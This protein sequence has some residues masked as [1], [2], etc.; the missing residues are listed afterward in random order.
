[1]KKLIVEFNRLNPMLK[2]MWLVIFTISI[3]SMIAIIVKSTGKDYD[4]S[5]FIST[6]ITFTAIMQVINAF[7][8]MSVLTKISKKEAN[9]R[10]LRKDIFT[11][12]KTLE[13]DLKIEKDNIFVIKKEILD[14]KKELTNKK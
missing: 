9:D 5:S 13:E 11:R 10:Y 2:T 7:F 1:M 8:L 6:N 3:V 12:L 4:L 14:I